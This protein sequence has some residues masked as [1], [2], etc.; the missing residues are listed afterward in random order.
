MAPT[1]QASKYVSVWGWAT[2]R[3]RWRQF[4]DDSPHL[5]LRQLRQRCATSAEKRFWTSRYHFAYE[6]SWD[7]RL[8]M[9]A[10]GNNLSAIYP[11]FPLIANQATVNGAETLLPQASA[12]HD[13]DKFP[14][15]AD[16]SHDERAFR[17]VW[18]APAMNPS[19]SF[20]GRAYE[21]LRTPIALAGSRAVLNCF[22]R[23]WASAKRL[24]RR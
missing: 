3:E 21:R 23:L 6:G 9:Y 10:L 2:W 16:S 7:Y 18:C 24:S 4:R 13:W 14:V 15:R 5:T 20:W 12:L 8:C 22:D 19:L 11:P 1:L 17:E